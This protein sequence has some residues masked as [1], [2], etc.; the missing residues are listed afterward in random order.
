MESFLEHI[1]LSDYKDRFILKGGMLV[2]AMAGLYARS[3]MDL[4]AMVKGVQC[5]RGRC[6]ISRTREVYVCYWK[7]GY[8]KKFLG[9]YEANIL[10]HKAAKKVF[11]EIDEMGVKRLPAIK[12]FWVEYAALL[13]KKK[14]PCPEYSSIRQEIQKLQI[15]RGNTVRLMGYDEKEQEQKERTEKGT[16]K[17]IE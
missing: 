2:A 10:L 6:G 7:V 5:R 17:R 8:S 13:S 11:D 3:T 14:K 1:A 16:E 4:D 9:E 12:S 15:A